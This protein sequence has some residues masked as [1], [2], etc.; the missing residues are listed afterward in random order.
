MIQSPALSMC[1][2]DVDEVLNCCSTATCQAYVS[3][4]SLPLIMVINNDDDVSE[5]TS[6]TLPFVSGTSVVIEI[7]VTGVI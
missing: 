6:K 3:T 2:D 4:L 1:N 7:V 5:N